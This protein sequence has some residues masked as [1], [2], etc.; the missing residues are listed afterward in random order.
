MKIGFFILFVFLSSFSFC[1]TSLTVVEP[2][3][4]YKGITVLSS[5]TNVVMSSLNSQQIINPS[6]KLTVPVVSLVTGSAQL[7]YGI[8]QYPAP[9]T[10]YPTTSETTIEDVKSLSSFNITIGA[11]TV[12]IST[13]NLI[14]RHKSI[15]KE[16]A[17]NVYPLVQPKQK[18]GLAFHFTMTI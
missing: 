2:P 5:A 13:I 10:T 17:F 9:K 11:S 3:K 12:L 15:P 6:F 16:T 1:Q 7:V 18:P 8:V 14:V 4:Y